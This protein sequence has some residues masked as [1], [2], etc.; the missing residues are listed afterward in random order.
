MSCRDTKKCALV[1]SQHHGSKNS[2]APLNECIKSMCKYLPW[3]LA[4]HATDDTKKKLVA[5]S[6]NQLL[7]AESLPIQEGG[8]ENMMW[9]INMP[10]LIS[11]LKT[12]ADTQEQKY[13]KLVEKRNENLTLDST[14]LS[15]WKQLLI[16]AAFV[17]DDT[18]NLNHGW[19]EIQGTFNPTSSKI[20]RNSA[21]QVA[22]DVSLCIQVIRP[23]RKF[24][25]G[26]YKHLSKW[27]K[28]KPR[29]RNRDNTRNQD[30]RPERI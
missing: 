2:V 5:G 9:H 28:R 8:N 4:V 25:S 13:F 15:C 11:N 12:L 22:R 24:A 19:V 30:E 29:E 17:V 16:L 6:T 23:V 7:T 10:L 21:T 14:I 1:V 27:E 26:A 20:I 18:V 3:L